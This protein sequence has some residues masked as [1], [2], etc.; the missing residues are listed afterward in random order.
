MIRSASLRRLALAALLPL[1]ALAG[2]SD[3]F[4]LV[5]PDIENTTFAS[6]LGVD[7]RAST[8]TTNGVYVRDLVV[9]TGAEATDGKRVAVRYTGYLKTGTLFDTN[10]DPG[11]ALFSFSIAPGGG[12][13]AGF[14]EGV[15][16][17]KVGGRRQIVIPPSQGYGN[18]PTGS[19]PANSILIFTVE[20]MSVT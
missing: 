8:R 17:M 13:I 2:C 7:I 10:T 14:I 6:S 9:G 12:A 5:A 19:I 3:E 18:V 16:G 15:K 11:E 4:D 20:L 1:A